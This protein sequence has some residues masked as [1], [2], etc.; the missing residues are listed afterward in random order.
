MDKPLSANEEVQAAL[1]VSWRPVSTEV[2]TVQD[3]ELQRAS[4]GRGSSARRLARDERV[5]LLMNAGYKLEHI[6]QIQEK[7]RSLSPKKP[8]KSKDDSKAKCSKIDDKTKAPKTMLQRVQKAAKKMVKS[9][10]AA[11]SSVFN[12]AA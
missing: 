10:D 9:N 11:R 3:F 5:A 2:T 1:T 4:S 12:A 7:S 6:C 8:T